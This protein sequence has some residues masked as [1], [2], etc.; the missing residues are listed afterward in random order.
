MDFDG[1]LLAIPELNAM[2]GEYSPPTELL[3]V[4]AG[5]FTGR[6]GTPFKNSKPNKVVALFKKEGIALAID[7]DH[8]IY[9]N[10]GG[11]ACGW[12]KK[13]EIREGAIW[14]TEIEWLS[15]ARWALEDKKYKYYS[16]HYVV[17]RASR[18]IVRLDVVSLVNRPRLSV[19]ALNTMEQ[20]NYS[21]KE[22]GM[23]LQ[24]ELNAALKNNLEFI[25]Q[26]SE[27]EAQSQPIA[28]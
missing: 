2:N 11:A 4:P 9:T 23:N 7:F 21:Q 3:L 10:G 26:A 15:R 13:L 27:A 18:E 5:D 24:D 28:K 14:G 1:N 19:Q 25:K 22:Q 8:S 6:D 17:D 12:I 20:N 16:P